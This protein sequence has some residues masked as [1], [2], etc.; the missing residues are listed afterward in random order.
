MESYLLEHVIDEL[1]CMFFS[2]CTHYIV[3]S[4]ILLLDK[5]VMGS[6]VSSDFQTRSLFSTSNLFVKVTV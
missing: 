1:L 5:D 2:K 3:N 4:S 6:L